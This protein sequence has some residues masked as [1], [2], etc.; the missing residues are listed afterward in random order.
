MWIDQDFVVLAFSVKEAKERALNTA[1][2]DEEHQFTYFEGD[3][4]VTY[5][6]LGKVNS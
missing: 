4:H 2:N 3:K 6:V 1:K 5:D